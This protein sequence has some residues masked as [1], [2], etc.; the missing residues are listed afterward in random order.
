[1]GRVG[2]VIIRTWQT[3]RQDEAAARRRCREERGRQRQLPRASAT[4]RNTRSTRRSR[5][6]WRSTIGSVEV[7]KLADL[8]LWTP[9]F[10]GVKPDLVIKGGHDR[11][12]ADGRSQ[13][14]DPDAAAGALPA[15]VRRLR[16]ARSRQPAST[17]VS[18]AARRGSTSAAALGLEQRAGR[19]R[20][21]PRRSAR[22]DM[23]HNDA[24]AG[25]R[26]R[27][28]DLR[29]A[30]RRRA[31]DLRAGDGAADGAALL[32]VLISMRRL[33]TKRRRGG[34]AGRPRRRRAASRSPSTIATGA[35]CG[36]SPTP[37]RPSCSICRGRSAGRGRRAGLRG[38][39]LARG[40]CG[41]ED[42]L[43]I[44]PPTTASWR[45]SPGISATATCRPRSWPGRL[46]IRHDHV[47]AGHAAA[48][49]APVSTRQP[50]AVRARDRRLRRPRD[51]PA[52]D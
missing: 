41:R 33:V 14:L 13:R 16:R 9:A 8:V 1:M 42:V 51:Q 43:E 28:R 36:C 25:D 39:R 15:D 5:T 27:P 18:E 19:G 4:S 26:G 34:A 24:T 2:E 47:I 22:R 52:S 48:G 38:R 6:A 21:H 20:G 7:G 30:R 31:S 45:A 40:A 37:A 11:R 17:F 32:P 10:F 49:W 46:R 29:G 23:M 50:R 12:R 44:A 35:A 3:A